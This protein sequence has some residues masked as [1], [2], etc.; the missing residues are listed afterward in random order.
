[1][2]LFGTGMTGEVTV[3]MGGVKAE[4]QSVGPVGEGLYAIS[5][6]VPRGVSGV[7]PVRVT[8]G[9]VES[10]GGVTIVVE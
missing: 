6:R 1:M 3:T 7:A 9:G 5:V 8:S 4:V 10:P 2:K